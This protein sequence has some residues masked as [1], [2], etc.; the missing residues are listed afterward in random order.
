MLIE[1]II[2]NKFRNRHVDATLE[3]AIGLLVAA[4][5]AIGL[6]NDRAELVFAVLITMILLEIRSINLKED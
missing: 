6:I 5:M 4:A 1:Y 3:F 2:K